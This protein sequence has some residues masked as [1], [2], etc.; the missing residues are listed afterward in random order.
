MV[1]RRIRDHVATHNWFAVTV[2]LAIV[3]VGVFLGMQANNWNQVRIDRER[4]QEYRQRLIDDLDANQQDFQQRAAYYRDVHDLGYAALQDLRRPQSADPVAFLF[5]AYKA[6]SILPRSTQRATYQ[7]ILSAGATGTLGD[8]AI[9]QQIANYYFGL[10]TTTATIAT[11]PP[12]RDRLRSG[13]PYEVQ[14]AIRSDCPEINS[15]DAKGRP[16]ISLG[17]GCSPKLDSVV[18]ASAARQ[19]RSIPDIQFDLTRSLVDDDQKILQ[20]QTMALAASKLRTILEATVPRRR[21]P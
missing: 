16:G 13:M 11:L 1:I 14:R 21:E 17:V 2:D 10:D 9:R 19:V 3:V 15:E 8:E 5:N 18:A 20:F 7:E 12:Y 6:T 4:G